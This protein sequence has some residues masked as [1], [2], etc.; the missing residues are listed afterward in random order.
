[1]RHGR[2]FF[3]G[4]VTVLAV[5]LSTLVG[6][7]AG[8]GW[9]DIIVTGN[10]NV[11]NSVKA[12]NG[13]V[14]DIDAMS[15]AGGDKAEPN[16][17]KTQSDVLKLMYKG[18]K[19]GKENVNATCTLAE[20]D[21]TGVSFCEFEFDGMQWKQADIGRAFDE[22]N[23]N[24][25]DLYLR[26]NVGNKAAVLLCS[27]DKNGKITNTCNDLYKDIADKKGLKNTESF[28]ENPTV[29][30]TPEPSTTILLLGALA[31]TFVILRKRLTVAE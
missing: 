9:A 4:A 23:G 11:P 25:S 2:R 16:D 21:E 26:L 19:E 28:K 8:L 5:M 1:M 15:D 17:D 14:V 31:F 7:T 10:P 6:L 3:N 30:S 29:N 13:T 12:P 27:D 22:G 20:K 18:G 24:S